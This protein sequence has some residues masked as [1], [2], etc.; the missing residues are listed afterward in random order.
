RCDPAGFTI[1]AMI[2][3]NAHNFASKHVTDS[4]Q[5]AR[6]SGLQRHLK[7]G[8][9]L[10]IRSVGIVAGFRVYGRLRLLS[11]ADLNSPVHPLLRS[12]KFGRY[13]YDPHNVCSWY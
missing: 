3:V 7:V 6:L 12:T 5:T 2:K 10:W 9:R 13:C 1:A 4:G 8:P 11:V